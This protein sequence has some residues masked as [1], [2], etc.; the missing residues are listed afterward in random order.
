MT[1]PFGLSQSMAGET[2]TIKRLFIGDKA[3]FNGTLL[4]DQAL[5][6]VDLD[7][8]EK[9]ICERKLHDCGASVGFDWQAFIFGAATGIL[10]YEII[11]HRDSLGLSQMHLSN[12][13]LSI[14]L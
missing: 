11:E 7:V 5:R 1:L 8:L 6:D 9:N 2:G 14:P 3:P 4:D 13:G 12:R 10:I